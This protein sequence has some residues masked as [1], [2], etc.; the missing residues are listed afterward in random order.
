MPA[1]S[2]AREREAPRKP[3]GQSGDPSLALEARGGAVLTSQRHK[4]RR[5]SWTLPV[6]PSGTRECDAHS[7]RYYDLPPPLKLVHV[8]NGVWCALDSI[9]V[10]PART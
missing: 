4:K 8:E 3:R 6:V 7:D 1:S 10:S 2:E 9:L 5:L